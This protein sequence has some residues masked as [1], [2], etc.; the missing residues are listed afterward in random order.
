M[1]VHKYITTSEVDQPHYR[2]LMSD[3]HIGSINSDQAEIVADLE[4][5]RAANA[6]I[7]IN[8]DVFD[9]IGPTDKRY[10]LTTLHPN[11]R[12]EK[13]LVAAV[14]KMACEILAPFAD[15]I[16]GIGIGNHEEAWI[17]YNH[18]DPVRGL[19]DRL[20]QTA[21]L[22]HKIRHGGFCGW[23]VNQFKLPGVRKRAVH[24]LY[25]LHGTGGDS[26][27]TKGT[28]DFNRKGRNFNYDALT[29][30]HKHNLL[31]GGESILDVTERGNVNER[32]QLNLQ[33][34]SYYRNYRQ[35][36]QADPLDYSYAESKGHP[37]K[38]MGGLFLILRPS[39]SKQ[40]EPFVRQDFASDFIPPWK[41]KKKAA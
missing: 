26:P 12:G 39:L 2:F 37:P 33:T 9:A 28:I 16:D 10:D 35:N 23:I 6:R 34:G 29:F 24:K 22:D 30:G 25:Y 40:N 1:I 21:K 7:F 36:T 5:A 3:L 14:V 19:I 41:P 15:L 27:V 13:D 4:A 8:G 20:H 11:I 38:P 32:V 31:A 18:G 17:R